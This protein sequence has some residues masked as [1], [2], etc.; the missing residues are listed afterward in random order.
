MAMSN[1]LANKVLNHLIGNT[2]TAGPFHLALLS[3]ASTE[4][5]AADYARVSLDGKMTLD[6]D[7]LT[8][9]EDISFAQATSDW[10]PVSYLAVY[11]A[12]TDGEVYFT[13]SASVIKA[14]ATGDV[15][16]IVSGNF[17]IQ[18]V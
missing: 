10:G 8:L 14:V 11:N 13:G 3:D 16:T 12:L 15:Y 5:D 1:T 6:S 2:F 9:T 4:I 7:T 18:L 17:S